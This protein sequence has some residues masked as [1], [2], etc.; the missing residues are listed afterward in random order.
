MGECL[1]VPSS[2]VISGVPASQAPVGTHELEP[3]KTTRKIQ[4]NIKTIV[5]LLT[6]EE[7]CPR[8]QWIMQRR[9]PQRKD[10]YSLNLERVLG[11]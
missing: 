3:G 10:N 6:L 4:L 9:F 1:D 11:E 5:Q 2:L 7:L 8:A